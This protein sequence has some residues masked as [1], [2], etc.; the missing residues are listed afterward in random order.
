MKLARFHPGAIEALR[1]FPEEV[2]R[3]VGKAIY[4][5][6]SGHTLSMPLSR[7]MPMLSRGAAE[8]PGCRARAR[9][10]ATEG[11]AAM[12]KKPKVVTVRNAGELAEALGLERADGI[13][14]AVRSALNTKIIEVVQ[15]RGLTHAAVA[16]LAHTSRTRVTAIMS[17][18]T[19]DVSTD[20]LLRVLGALGVT[21]KVTFGRA[22]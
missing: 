17:R 11:D 19:K 4:D 22:A 6:Q 16:A 18:N 12:R 21:A 20:L 8:L 1:T 7:P 15:R 14:L 3:A 9:E 10:E 2:R 5:L 13:E